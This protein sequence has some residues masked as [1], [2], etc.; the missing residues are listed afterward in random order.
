MLGRGLESL[1]PK[2]D[3]KTVAPKDEVVQ[4]ANAN[5]AHAEVKI[6]EPAPRAEATSSE[7]V[8]QLEVEKIKPN[9]HQPRREFNEENLKE[10]AASIREFGVI[11]PIIVSKINKETSSGTD[12]E[13]QLIAGE[14]RL[15]ASKL[16]GL[17]RIPAIVRKVDHD[18]EN[19][20]I[21][22][23]ENLQR[24]DLNAIESARAYAKLQE[25]FGLTQR[26]IAVR[27]GKSREAIAN[28]MRLLNLPA[29]IQDAIGK[30]IITESQGRMI[31][32]VA[33]PMDQQKLFEDILKSP[34]KKTY[35]KIAPRDTDSPEWMAIKD[36]LEEFLGTKVQ[37][38][39]T[40]NGGKLVIDFYSPEEL[41]GI[42][43]KLK[44]NKDTDNQLS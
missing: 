36:Q 27:I 11:Q 29:H 33:S 31:L 43:R 38:Q 35:M 21:A 44:T 41:E 4:D 34:G 28:T 5:N 13:Y 22:I 6:P 17:P 37:L 32:A 30:N 10:L 40:A 39:K 42:L 18:K 9:P 2:K 15:M 16:T 25:V 8:F 1:I 19:L 26:E 23:I 14:R 20:E 7:P 24:S 12:V 3:L